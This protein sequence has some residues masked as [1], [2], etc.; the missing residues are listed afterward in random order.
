MRLQRVV[1]GSSYDGLVSEAKKL[2]LGSGLDAERGHR[3]AVNYQP[4][5]D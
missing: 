3:A 5:R 2:K 4:D 1:C